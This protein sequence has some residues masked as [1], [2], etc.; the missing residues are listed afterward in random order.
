MKINVRLLQ[1]RSL[2]VRSGRNGTVSIVQD[3]VSKAYVALKRPVLREEASLLAEITH[4]HVPAY[5][6]YLE[7]ERLLLM[8]WIDGE[9]LEQYLQRRRHLSVRDLHQFFTQLGNV[10]SLLEA[11]RPPLLYLD[12]HPGNV[13][14]RQSDGR[15]FL[16]D[17]G[18]VAR[19]SQ[20]CS[21][22]KLLLRFLTED[23]LDSLASPRD[24]YDQVEAWCDQMSGNLPMSTADLL[25]EWSTYVSVAFPTLTR[26][27]RA[28]RLPVF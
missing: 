7:E 16:I 1:E 12:L 19:C 18:G 13:M 6:G 3:Q 4:P 22:T 2:I 25:Q 28:E 9:T 10:F 24:A 5:Y 17:F 15:F 11:R 27:S 14:R 23:L 8:E 21:H 20:R 26:V